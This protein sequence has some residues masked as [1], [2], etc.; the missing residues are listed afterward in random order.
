[1][2]KVGNEIEFM[3]MFERASRRTPAE[4]TTQT[5]PNLFVTYY[6]ISTPFSVCQMSLPIN[7]T[8]KT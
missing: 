6:Y 3:T 7:V 1:V 8:D 4:S 5:Q 2:H